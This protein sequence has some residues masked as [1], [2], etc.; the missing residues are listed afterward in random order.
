MQDVEFVKRILKSD[1]R[2][3]LPTEIPYPDLVQL[4]SRTD[5]DFPSGKVEDEKD[6][7]SYNRDGVGYLYFPDSGKR[8]LVHRFIVAVALRKW[9]PRDLDVHHINDKPNDNNPL[10][11][12]V[13]TRRDNNHARRAP[14][15]KIADLTVAEMWVSEIPKIDKQ[16]KKKKRKHRSAVLSGGTTQLPDG[17][18]APMTKDVLRDYYSIPE[19][20][21]WTGRRKGMNECYW[22]ATTGVWHYVDPS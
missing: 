11:L 8:I 9:P 13:V 6:N 17:K 12:E 7:G 5:F 22:E 1:Y 18:R 16:V 2:T 15:K 14:L 4:I 10:N 19:G 20:V 21:I 3:H